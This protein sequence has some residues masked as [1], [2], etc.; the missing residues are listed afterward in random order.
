MTSLW[1]ERVDV[2]GEGC[3][4]NV[5][6]VVWLPFV[7][8]V[9]AECRCTCQTAGALPGLTTGSHDDMKSATHCTVKARG[10]VWWGDENGCFRSDFGDV[11]LSVTQKKTVFFTIKVD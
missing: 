11:V 3:C 8:E 10:E 1:A 6:V 2:E 4:Y 9:E 5:I 7:I